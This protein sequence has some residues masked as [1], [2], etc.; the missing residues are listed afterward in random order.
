MSKGESQQ[1]K[2]NNKDQSRNKLYRK[3]NKEKTVELT[4]KT[5]SWFFQ[6]NKI[7]PDLPKRKEK[8]SKQIKSQMKEERLQPTP[9]KYKL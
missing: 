6:I 7:E 9:Q 4:N 2:G 8:G 1:K 3:K 5:K